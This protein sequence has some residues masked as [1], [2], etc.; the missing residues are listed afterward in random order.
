M[1]FETIYTQIK[2]NLKK[3]TDVLVVPTGD[4]SPLAIGEG[5]KVMS[6][7]PASPMSVCAVAE[8]DEEVTSLKTSE[9][10]FVDF[11]TTVVWEKTGGIWASRGYNGQEAFLRPYT[12]I[13]SPWS[14]KMYFC[15][16]FL[17]LSKV[18]LD[19]NPTPL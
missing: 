12:F 16:G 15:D 6:L 3:L 10:R 5:G 1:S 11:R 13:R 9:T 19:P 8:T 18:N 4:A 7:V 2:A 17:N 14:K